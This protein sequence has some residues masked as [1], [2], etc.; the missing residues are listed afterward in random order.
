MSDQLNMRAV[1]DP[2][3]AVVGKLT[4][5][6]LVTPTQVRWGRT[7]CMKDR[8]IARIRRMTAFPCI[9][10]SHLQVRLGGH[11]VVCMLWQTL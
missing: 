3:G 6:Q 8:V 5:G 10:Y 1:P 9:L 7:P 2:N 11:F 4:K